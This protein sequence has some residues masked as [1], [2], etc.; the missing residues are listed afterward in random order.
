MLFR[1]PVTMINRNLFKVNEG[2]M[3][4]Q[5]FFAIFNLDIYEM[6]YLFKYILTVVHMFNC[7]EKN[8][9]FQQCILY[10][11][12]AVKYLTCRF[13]FFHMPL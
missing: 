10:L 12:F 9:R 11:A 7:Q 4:G 13:L 2:L 8:V 1:V 5:P 6:F 3:D